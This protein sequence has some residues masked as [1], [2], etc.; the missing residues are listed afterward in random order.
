MHNGRIFKRTGGGA[1]VDFRSVVDAVH[2]AIEVRNAMVERN[3]G[4][5]PERRI[6]FSKACARPGCRKSEAPLDEST[7]ALS[8]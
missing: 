3:V 4:V 2:C 5:P 8:S 6:E 1:L 7:G